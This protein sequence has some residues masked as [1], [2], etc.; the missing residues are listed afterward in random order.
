[1]EKKGELVGKSRVSAKKGVQFAPLEEE[2]GTYIVQGTKLVVV[3]ID[4]EE[5]IS[6]SNCEVVGRFE[7][8]NLLDLDAI[9]KRIA[10]TNKLK[11]ADDVY[12][13][14]PADATIA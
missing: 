9:D 1:M 7:G 12:D 3:R 14:T 6:T 2:S 10:K 4:L 8:G 5:E 13:D 11:I